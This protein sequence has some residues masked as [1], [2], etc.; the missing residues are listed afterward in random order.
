MKTNKNDWA[1]TYKIGVTFAVAFVV[2]VLICSAFLAMITSTLPK[3]SP[4]TS[5]VNLLLQVSGFY[6]SAFGVSLLFLYI[7]LRQQILLPVR[8]IAYQAQQMSRGISNREIQAPYSGE[9]GVLVASFNRMKRSLQREEPMSVRREEPP[10][11]RREEPTQT[12]GKN[13]P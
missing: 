7:L 2:P 3:D 9:L 6:I 11:A 10:Q 1:L 8:R 5:F 4:T 12:R 13:V